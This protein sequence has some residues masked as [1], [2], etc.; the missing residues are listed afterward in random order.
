ME[1]DCTISYK[2][3]DE[4]EPKSLTFLSPAGQQ[5][6]LNLSRAERILCYFDISSLDLHSP[7]QVMEAVTRM[8]HART[9]LFSHLST[10]I[11]AISNVVVYLH[12]IVPRTYYSIPTL[13]HL[14]SY[15]QLRNIYSDYCG[16]KLFGHYPF[17]H[18]PL[19]LPS[20]IG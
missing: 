20:A 7:R 19:L 2:T 16:C 13:L 14:H 1:T 3:A 11:P 9:D 10:L 12:F 18:C 17:V 8:G 4:L 15:N 6:E 5:I